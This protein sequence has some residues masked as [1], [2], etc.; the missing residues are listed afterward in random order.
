MSIVGKR[1]SKRQKLFNQNLYKLELKNINLYNEYL[2]LINN[3]FNIKLDYFKN[4]NFDK[5]I[6]TRTLM[7][8]MLQIICEH[9][10]AL[11]VG[12]ADLAPSTLVTY[13]KSLSFSP[14]NKDGQNIKYGVREF[15]MVSINNGILLHGGCRA[16]GSTFLSFSDYCKNAIRLAAISNLG[17]INIFSHDSIYVGE[18]GPTHQ[19]VEQI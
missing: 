12:N 4:I 3:K 18:D 16:I 14:A 13:K 1:G 10:S 7:S 17:N 15:A 5:H 8:N 19:P 6:A 2:N 11:M 9:N